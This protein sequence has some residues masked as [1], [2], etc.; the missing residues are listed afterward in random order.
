[1][2][3]VPPRINTFCELV[4]GV[5]PPSIEMCGVPPLSLLSV[6]LCAVSPPLNWN[7]RCPP[8]S[9]LSVNLCAVSPP[10]L[11]WN[12]RCPTP[13]FCHTLLYLGFSANS[14][15]VSIL[16]WN[17]C[18]PSL[19]VQLSVYLNL[20]LRVCHSQL[21]LFILNFSVYIS[22]NGLTGCILINLF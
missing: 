1:M 15:L 20:Y 17:V 12:V 5:P 8:L 10:S 11:K 9:L 7:V 14:K 6:N 16:K 3:G 18:P 2:C 4:C 21:S 13:N 19:V 22:E